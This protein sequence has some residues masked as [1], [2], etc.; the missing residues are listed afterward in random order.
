MKKRVYSNI[1]GKDIRDAKNNVLAN[2]KASNAVS[3]ETRH[4]ITYDSDEEKKKKL[5]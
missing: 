2:R 4:C 5:F 1:T 3:N